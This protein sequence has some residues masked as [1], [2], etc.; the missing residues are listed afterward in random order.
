M[1]RISDREL[2][3]YFLEALENCGM[4]LLNCEI[5]DIEYRIFEEFDGDCISFL[6]EAALLRLRDCGYI[7]PE[8][9]LKCRLLYEKF[10]RMENTGVLNAESV[11][12]NPEW[13]AVLSLADEIKSIIRENAGRDR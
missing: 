8:I 13:R 10:R 11:K 4:F 2:F 5:R 6:H 12:T 9:H 3:R 7:T 1:S